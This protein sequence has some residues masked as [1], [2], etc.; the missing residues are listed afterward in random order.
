MNFFEFIRKY[1]YLFLGLICI[2]AIGVLY[3]VNI[4][5]EA[6]VVSPGQIVRDSDISDI[7]IAQGRGESHTFQPEPPTPAEPEMIIVHILGAV[8]MPGVFE[9]PL[10]S[11]VNDAVGLAG[12]FTE[13]ADEL[14]VNLAAFVSDAMQIIIPALGDE[15]SMPIFIPDSSVA[16]GFRGSPEPAPG[17][18][19]GIVNINTANHTELQTL[20]GIGSVIA[21]NIIDFREANGGFSSV[22]ELINV[23]RIGSVTLEG[24]R[25]RVTVG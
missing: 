3:L 20:P 15:E 4:N 10:G 24:L 23:T 11:R 9:M 5:R 19:N 16:P 13:E 17:I 7:T 12:G 1:A 6:V 8:N 25:D 2:L 14:R 22:D 18:V 21:Q